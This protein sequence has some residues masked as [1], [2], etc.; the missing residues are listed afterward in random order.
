M[1]TSISRSADG[2]SG[3]PSR[4]ASGW[5]TFASIYLG[6]AGTIGVIYGVAALAN[7]D[8]FNDSGLL[9]SNLSSWGWLMIAL[10]ALQILIALQIH[11][12]TMAGAIGGMAIAVC[13]FIA[14]FLAIG[15]YPVWSVIAMVMNGFVLWALPRAI[16]D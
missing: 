15:A 8:F 10:G 11:R 2:R 16:E 1:Q 9:W 13:A 14:N 4:L 3:S 5:A 7:R 12:R 6:L